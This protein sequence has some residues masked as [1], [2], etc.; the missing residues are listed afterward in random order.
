M[1][2]DWECI[3]T[4]ATPGDSRQTY[5][6]KVCHGWIVKENRWVEGN[7]EQSVA[8]SMVFVPDPNHS[9]GKDIMDG[10]I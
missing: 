2:I 5:R 4:F 10:V 7:N 1:K 3:S 8:T 6:A 9:W